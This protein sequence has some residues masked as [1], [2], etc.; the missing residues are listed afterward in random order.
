MTNHDPRL[1]DILDVLLSFARRDFSRRAAVHGTDTVDAIAAGLNMLAEELH[2]EIASRRD[3]EVAYAELKAADARLVQA[4]KMVAIGQL[5]SAA[6]H[7]VN[8]PAMWV[9][10][11]LTL[12]GR[13]TKELRAN[14]GKGDIDR[15]ALLANL[16]TIDQ[17]LSN[18][19]EGMAR[20][21]LVIGDLRTFSRADEDVIEEV[22]MADIVRTSCNLARPSLCERAV[23]RLDLQETPA[24]LASRGRLAQ[25]VTNLLVNAA[26]AVEARPRAEEHEITISTRARDDGVLLLVEDT[27]DG[28]APELREKIFEP[29]FTTKPAT[30][31]TGLGLTIVAEIVR[32]Y[33]GFVRVADGARCGARFE[34]W[35]PCHSEAPRSHVA[36]VATSAPSSRRARILVV[37]DEPAILRAIR[38]VLENDDRD[39]LLAGSG[40][41]AVALLRTE[42]VDAV[43]CDLHMPD[44]DGIA[45][46][47]WLREQRPDLADRVIFL[48]EDS[49]SARASS[50]VA[51]SGAIVVSK[52]ISAGQL[53][54]ALARLLPSETLAVARR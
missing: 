44:F 29:L 32:G 51:S 45:L 28:V 8:N 52:P 38:R 30:T 6:A 20:I 25:V 35:L 13:A 12:I 2:G 23:L 43:L 42:T 46:N 9:S 31:G 16:E 48:A 15:A 47:A 41:D 17:V 5:A 21:R 24:L 19:T 18:G 36:P 50:F 33:G 22:S 3:L 34:V 4:S 7:E 26:Q 39:V 53:E 49:L 37:D 11:G 14:V 54:S 27:G 10:L 1:D 40:D